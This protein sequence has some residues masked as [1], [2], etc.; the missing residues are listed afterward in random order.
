M[1]EPNEPPPSEGFEPFAEDAN[2]RTIGGLSIENGTERIAIHGAVDLTRDRAGLE[3]ARALAEALAA[4]VRSLEAQA[5]PERLV[6]ARRQPRSVK[7]PFA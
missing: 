5:L 3:R 2:V 7:N 1:A 4:I 6:E